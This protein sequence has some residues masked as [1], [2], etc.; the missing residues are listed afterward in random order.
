MYPHERSL[1][2]KMEGRPF[3]LLGVNSDASREEVRPTL[4]KE[5]IT[6]RSW[7]NGPMGTGGRISK[8]WAI[9][10]WPTLILID[11]NGIIR[12]KYEGVPSEGGLDRDIEAL[13]KE[14]QRAKS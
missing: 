5:K 4:Q 1:V 14:A 9:Q 8:E 2:K 12:R 11:H 13:I 10:G 3:V 7:W 6:W